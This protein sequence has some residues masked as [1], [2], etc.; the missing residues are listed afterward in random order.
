[1]NKATDPVL[2]L[3]DDAPLAVTP[4]AINYELQKDEDA[5]SRRTI[6]R[7]LS[8]LEDRGYIRRVNDGN[9]LKITDRGEEYLRG[10]R[11]ASKDSN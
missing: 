6:F 1:M 5:P 7:A 9:I 10:E 11:D 3:L 2:E 4:G 8:E